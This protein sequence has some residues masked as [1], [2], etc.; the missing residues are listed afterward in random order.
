MQM[1]KPGA[2]SLKNYYTAAEKPAFSLDEYRKM[3]AEQPVVANQALPEEE[4]EEEPQPFARGGLA[5]A[6]IALQ[7]GGQPRLR[8]RARSFAKGATFAFNDEIEGLGR[9]L[10]S[11]QLSPEAYRDQ[12]T[13]I[14]MQQKAYEDANPIESLAFEGAGSILPAFVPGG[15]VAAAGR[16]GSLAAKTPMAVRRVAPVVRDAALY[17]MGSADSMR[18]IPRAMGEEAAFG[19]GMYGAGRLAARPAKAGYRK[20]R[21]IFR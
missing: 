15:Q 3:I 11:G 20:V 7:R 6:P 19:V 1:E 2:M 16:L 17:G 13:R 10:M 12:V 4:E 18:D 14:R 9:M 21:S 8:D 5:V